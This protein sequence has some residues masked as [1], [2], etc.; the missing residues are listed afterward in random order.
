VASSLNLIVD[1]AVTESIAVAGTPPSGDKADECSDTGADGYSLI[2]A[3]MHG[4]IGGLRGLDRFV[5]ETEARVFFGVF[6]CG[7][8]T[9]A[10]LPVLFSG[11]HRLSRPLGRERL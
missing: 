1:S 5:A 2:G 6:Q 7:G 4:F 10:A 8:E 3:F 9:R 11:P